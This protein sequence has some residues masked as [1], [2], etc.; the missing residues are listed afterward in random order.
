MPAKDQI[1]TE[2]EKLLKKEWW[3]TPE[4]LLQKEKLKKEA[5]EKYYNNPKI[6]LYC[7]KIIKWNKK[8]NKKKFCDRCCSAKY[9]NSIRDPYINKKVSETLKEKY[10]AGLLKMPVTKYHKVQCTIKYCK[11]CNKEIR[12]RPCE[13]KYK[14]Y[15]SQECHRK[16]PHPKC[17]PGGYRKNSGRGKCG[18]YKGYWC[19]SSYELAF[20][21]YNIDHDIKFDR[22]KEG[23]EYIFQDIKHKF[24][25]DFIINGE[26]Y[27]LKGFMTPQQQ[28]KIDQFPYKIY[29]IDKILI[30]PYI[31]YVVNKYGINFIGLYEENPN[32]KL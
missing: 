30:K 10:K 23:F 18:W 2:E 20:V 5:E 6:C 16:D 8:V 21:L 28:A 14:T 26:Y 19:Q 32:K 22:N 13:L 12:V 29:L 15:C 31:D 4:G 11:I 17:G 25:P 27:E 3:N 7:N 9:N 1:L 24:Y